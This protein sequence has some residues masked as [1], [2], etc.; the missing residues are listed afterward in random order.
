MAESTEGEERRKDI[1]KMITL[2]R[3]LRVIR[4][5]KMMLIIRM[6]ALRKILKLTVKRM[7]KKE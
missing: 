1:L 4:K 5:R 2:N 6:K 3:S 7:L